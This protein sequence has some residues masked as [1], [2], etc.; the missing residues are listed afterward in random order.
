MDLDQL[1]D[2]IV[3]ITEKKIIR[4]FCNFGG[5]FASKRN[6]IGGMFKHKRVYFYF[7]QKCY[8]KK[9]LWQTIEALVG[10]L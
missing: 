9:K 7:V 5:K 1:V 4:G 3:K 2:E 8:T 6:R 10:R